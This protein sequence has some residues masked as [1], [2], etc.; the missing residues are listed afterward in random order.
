MSATGLNL[1]SVGTGD[2]PNYAATLWVA[3]PNGAARKVRLTDKDTLSLIR[4]LAEIME[5][6]A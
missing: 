1:I 5:R 4:K 3:T 2:D 6:R